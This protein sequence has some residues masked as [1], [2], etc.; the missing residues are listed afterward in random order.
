[1]IHV[2]GNLLVPSAHHAHKSAHAPRK[3]ICTIC[4]KSFPFKSGLRQHMTVHIKQKCHRCFA[5]NCKRSYKWASDLNQHV[6]THVDRK[7]QCPDCNYSSREERLYKRHLKSTSMNSNTDVL[8]VTLKQSGQ[9]HSKG[10]QSA[11]KLNA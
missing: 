3:H 6:K 2:N 4:S 8:F 5:G 9:P 1:M 11:V 7:H 10:I